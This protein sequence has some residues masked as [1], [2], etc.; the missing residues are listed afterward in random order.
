M[1]G[2]CGQRLL[3]DG[4]GWAVCSLCEGRGCTLG[5]RLWTG[6]ALPVRVPSHSRAKPAEVT[7]I[8]VVMR[9]ALLLG[10]YGY[11]SEAQF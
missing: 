1:V 2:L 7:L 8:L 5:A 11:K 3:S 9:Q 10:N 6:P 4:A